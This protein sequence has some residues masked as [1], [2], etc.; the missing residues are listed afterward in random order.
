MTD[1]DKIE[2]LFEIV[3]TDLPIIKNH[4]DV[5]VKTLADLIQLYKNEINLNLDFGEAYIETLAT[6]I[7][8][9]TNTALQLS[10]GQNLKVLDKE[11]QVI[12]IS[13]LYVVARSIIECFLTIEYLF[14]SDI[15]QEERNFRF[16]LW[17]IAG[18]M[19]RQQA[20][21]DTNKSHS[22]KIESEKEEIDKLKEEVKE[23]AFYSQLSNHDIWKLDT[24]GIPRTISWSKLLDKSSINNNLLDGYYKLYSNYAHSE[25]VSIMQLSQMN[26]NIASPTAVYN[27]TYTLNNIRIINCVVINLFLQKFKDSKEIYERFDAKTKYIID[28]WN[29]FATKEK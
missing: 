21:N 18:F 13:S 2:T 16:K 1:K 26:L 6:K 25:F 8:L 14:V 24:F 10:N 9:A 7:L 20:I 19:M 23:S 22:A 3:S 29:S 12:D 28:F 11:I 5:I 15:S 27:S 17:K 4:L